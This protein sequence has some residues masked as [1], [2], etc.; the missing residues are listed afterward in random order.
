LDGLLALVVLGFALHGAWRGAITQGFSLVGVL[1]GLWAAGWIAQWVGQHWHG[2]RPAV[3]FFVVKWLVAG[4][5]GLAL[6]TGLQW[7]G[8]SMGAAARGG[9]LGWVDRVAGLAVGAA[10]GT[11]VVTI[12]LLAALLVA[13]PREI[14]D[15]AAAAGASGPLM[16]T[17]A[18]ACDTA[19]GLLP[20][21]GWL[22]S[23][24]RSAYERT[25][26]HAGRS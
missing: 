22:E 20:G 16:R 14:P 9:P 10:Y 5:G 15:T 18:S 21:G 23:R 13:W 24:F 6:A 2:A 8:E 4:L 11:I 26:S 17:A 25:R 19:G 12:G 7:W 1:V 3:L